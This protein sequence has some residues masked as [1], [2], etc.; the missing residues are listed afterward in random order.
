[1]TSRLSFC[2][3]QVIADVDSLEGGPYYL[4]AGITLWIQLSP[5]LENRSL[6][7]LQMLRMQSEDRVQGTRL[8]LAAVTYRDSMGNQENCYQSVIIL[9]SFHL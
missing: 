8:N 1:M 5:R 4:G 9:S 6:I 7:Q 2:A 3:N